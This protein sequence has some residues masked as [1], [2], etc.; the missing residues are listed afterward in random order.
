MPIKDTVKNIDFFSELDD[1]QLTELSN[2]S[3]VIKY[4]KNSILYYESEVNNHILFLVSGLLKVYKVDKFDNEIFL[5]HIYENSMISELSSI[6]DEEIFCF[7]NTE[8]IE[9]SVVLSIDFKKFKELFLSKNICC[10]PK[11]IAPFI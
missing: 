9:N 1:A 6:N 7:S 4:P 3:N 8:F 2:I 5:Y 10:I 11:G